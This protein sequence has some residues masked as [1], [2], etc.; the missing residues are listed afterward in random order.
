MKNIPFPEYYG[1]MN[2]FYLNINFS[3]AVS[4]VKLKK[5]TAHNLTRQEAR[6]NYYTDQPC[7]ALLNLCSYGL[8]TFLLNP[9]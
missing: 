3:V 4:E 9:K 2:R 8:A 5:I 7:Q 6:M 1:T